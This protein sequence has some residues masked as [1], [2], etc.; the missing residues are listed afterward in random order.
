VQSEGACWRVLF[1]KPG[2]A[3][4]RSSGHDV[5]TFHMMRELRALG[6]RVA[7]VTAEPVVREALA[8]LDLDMV[9]TLSDPCPDTR[10]AVRLTGLQE[11]FREY[12]GVPTEHVARLGALAREWNAD[13]VVVSGLNVLPM[14]GGVHSALRIWYAADEWLLHHLSLVHVSRPDTWSELRHGVIKGLYEWSYGRLLDRTWVVSDADARAMRWLARRTEVDIVANGVDAAYYAPRD[15]A[16]L[17]RSAVFWGRLDFGPNIQAL[18]WFLGAV[19]PEVRAKATDAVMTIAGFSPGPEVKR[20]A[21]APGVTLLENL[22]DLRDVVARHQVVVLPFVSGAGIKNKLLEAAA[23]GKAVLATPRTLG[24]L[25]G[26]P[27]LVVA[28]GRAQWTRALIELWGDADRRQ[29]LGGAARAWVVEHQTWSAAA[30]VAE[31]GIRRSLSSRGT[32]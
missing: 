21:S 22:P 1:F 10:P 23:M 3:W 30:R 25:Q 4:P 5:H 7:L 15:E 12:W 6:H 26:E 18:E 13:V 19:W 14:L 16:G 20:V 29:R 28:S 11:R 24:G 31:R 17:A 32:A 9:C 27:P 8:G 2:L